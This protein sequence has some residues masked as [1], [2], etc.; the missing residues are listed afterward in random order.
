MRNEQRQHLSS[1]YR[2]TLQALQK[3]KDKGFQY[4]QIE[5]F[6]TDRRLDYMEPS[7]FLLQPLMN[8]PDD[9]NKKGIYEPINSQILFEWAKRPEEGIKVLIMGKE[10]P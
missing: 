8:L 9:I 10:Q 1:T 7:Y 5:G 6:T 2:L 4:V 3:L